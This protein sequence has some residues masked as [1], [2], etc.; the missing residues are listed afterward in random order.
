MELFQLETFLA[1]AET[2]SFSR[3]AQK[4][5]RTQPAVSQTIR[6][7]ESDVGEP[8]FDRSSRDANL[9]DAGRL[10]V[11][12]AEKLLNLRSEAGSAIVEL[13]QLH[14]GKLAIAANEFT[15]IY[16]LPVLEKFRRQSPMIKVTV[17]RSLSSQI[18]Q[19]VLNHKVEMGMLSFS[20]DV[21]G[22]RSTVVYKDE[23][24]FV[25][26]PRHPLASAKEV[27]IRQLGAESFIAHNVPSQ[28]RAKVLEAFRRHKT[29]L[30]MQVELPT[31]EAIKRFVAMGNGVAL[32]PG[33][34]VETELRRG[35]LVHVP[36]R[37]LKFE[38]K[39]RIVYRR[40]SS[41]SH[42]ARA[43]LKVIE[44]V[45]SEKKGRYAFEAE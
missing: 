15:S 27:H 18:A 32:V 31:I 24:A 11:D 41:L 45:A 35:E 30:N 10:L 39:L 29:P 5:H 22:L 17:Q 6:K 33:V 2:R 28:Y 26:H 7:L 8:L 42:A 14:A 16:L 1:V 20:P 37:E 25:V 4:L 38:R 13:R 36:V 44:A 21:T 19:E 9:T 23:L 40:N 34:C 3:A 12:Y 43:F